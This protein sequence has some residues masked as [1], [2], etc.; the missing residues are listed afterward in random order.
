MRASRT[1]GAEVQKGNAP[2]ERKFQRLFRR[3]RRHA[4][5][6]A[7]QRLWRWRRLRRHGRDRRRPASSTWIA[8][9]KKYD[10]LDG[11]E[12]A[13]S[14][15]QERMAVCRRGRRRR[16]S[17]S[18]TPHEENLE[19]TV[20]ADRHRGAARASCTWN[21]E[22]DRRRE[23]CVPQLQRRVEAR[24]TSTSSKAPTMRPSWEG[25]DASRS[26]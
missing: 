19:A 1:C 15:S 2:V 9:P 4:P 16:R 18:G 10:G 21:G 8:F 14:E 25:D 23:P 24:R 20:I 6:Q 3:K 26:A 17:S 13:I 5:H 12:L 22:H 11:T 7:L